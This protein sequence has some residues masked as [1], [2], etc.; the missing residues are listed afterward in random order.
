[1]YDIRGVVRDFENNPIQGV[2]V[3]LSGYVTD[4]V[5][6]SAT[7]YY[8]F[9]NIW[10]GESYTITPTKAN[11]TFEPASVEFSN[12]DSDKTQDFIGK[13]VNYNSLR[14]YP[15]PANEFIKFE[16]IPYNTTIKIYNIAGDEIATLPSGARN[17]SIQGYFIDWDLTNSKGKKV[18]SGVYIYILKHRDY[19][20]VKGKIVVNR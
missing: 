3:N 5:I 2:S 14:V 17:D 9:L 13:A 10:G 19:G 4:S 20:V 8:E 6:T 12:L 11:Y 1:V 7:G 16:N 18:A 15:N